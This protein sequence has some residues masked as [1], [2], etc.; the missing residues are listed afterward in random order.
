VSMFRERPVVIESTQWRANGDHPGDHVGDRL[1]DPMG[2]PMY[3]RLEMSTIR[4]CE[5]FSIA[6]C[7]PIPLRFSQRQIGYRHHRR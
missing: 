6:V 2:G 5:P 7:S 1:D 4:A 3:L